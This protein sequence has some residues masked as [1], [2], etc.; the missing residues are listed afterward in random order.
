MKLL[1]CGAHAAHRRAEVERTKIMIDRFEVQ[2]EIKQDH[3]ID[4]TVYYSDSELLSVMRLPQALHWQGLNGRHSLN[5]A[6]ILPVAPNSHY[7]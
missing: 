4:Y 2:F 7:K 6:S 1:L 3:L 5:K